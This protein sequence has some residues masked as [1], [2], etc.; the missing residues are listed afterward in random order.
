MSMVIQN[1]ATLEG[2]ISDILEN[3]KT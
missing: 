3:K 2:P 1:K